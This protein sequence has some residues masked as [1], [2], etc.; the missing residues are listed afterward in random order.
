MKTHS[1]SRGLVLCVL[2]AGCHHVYR[3]GTGGEPV[4]AAAPTTALDQS[5]ACTAGLRCRVETSCAGGAH[6]TLSGTV[7]AP[8]GTLPLYNATVYVPNAPV[9]AFTKGVTCDRCDGRVSGDPIAIALTGPD[10]KFTLTNVPSGENVPLVIQ[11]GR[12]RRQVV[13]PSV[14]GCQVTAL[15]DVELTRLPRNASEGD[16][17]QIAIATGAA[18]PF[19]CLLLKVGIDAKEITS[20][21]GANPGR[22]HFYRATDAPGTDLASHAPRANELYSSLENLLQYDVV[23]LPCEGGAFDK[24][25]VDGVPLTPNPRPLFEQYLDAGGRVFATHLSYDWYT[26]D[27][28]PF[29]K[30]AAPVNSSGTWPVG[31]ADDY[32]DTIHGL[33]KETFP[34]GSDFAKWLQFAGVSSEPGQLDILNG[35][36]DLTAVDPQYAQPWVVYDFSPQGGGPAVMHMTFN[37]PLDP[38]VDDMGVPAYCGR[39]VFSDFH[40]TATALQDPGVTPALPFP[41]ACKQ[42]PLTDQEKAL[43]FMLF[44]LSSCV[45][46]DSQPPVL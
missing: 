2:L 11:L 30:I 9:A 46:S 5:V 32:N 42:E 14:P 1:L 29:N 22:V 8:N 37:S 40:V 3:A 6:T 18:D 33:I 15:D 44:D 16:L 28:S 24:S 4:D 17:P 12:W 38:Q 26:Y 7:F 20:P 36:H 43:V 19:E 27:E 35:R 39:T 41:A 21:D 45:Q 23:L 10:G 31:Q 34:K 25:I 13:I